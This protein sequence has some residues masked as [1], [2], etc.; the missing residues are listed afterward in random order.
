MEKLLRWTSN[1]I[2]ALYITCI[3]IFM[4]LVYKK[5]IN[6]NEIPSILGVV[7][8]IV[9]SGSMKSEI[10]PGD[11]IILKKTFPQKINI[12][13]IIT[14]K[15]KGDERI[16]ITHRVTK[17]VNDGGKTKFKTKGDVNCTED[18]TLISGNQIIGKEIFKIPY[19]GYVVNF[20]KS[21]TGIFLFI[22]IPLLILIGGEIK[23]FLGAKSRKNSKN[24][25]KLR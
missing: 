14:Y 7:P 6:P 19:G 24:N 13:E 23:N 11:L 9:L 1:A 15:D 10:N 3:I 12:G 8:L 18:E 16:L 4:N 5:I 2:I 20:I 17:I 22:I 25:L 21:K